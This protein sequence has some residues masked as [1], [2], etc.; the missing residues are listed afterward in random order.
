MDGDWQIGH[1]TADEYGRIANEAAKL[2]KLVDPKIELVVCGSSVCEL[3]TFGEWELTVLDHTYD[4]V[5]YISLH[6]YYGNQSNN[7][8]MFQGKL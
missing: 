7:M 6:Q 1:K 3:E 2:M 4:N 5:D 8:K